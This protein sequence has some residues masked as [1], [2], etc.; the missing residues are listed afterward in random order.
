MS[1][2]HGDLNSFKKLLEYVDFDKDSLII[3]G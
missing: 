2:I 1:D 3:L